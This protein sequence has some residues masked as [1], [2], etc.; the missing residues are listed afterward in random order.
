M[1]CEH[2]PLTGLFLTGGPFDFL[3]FTKGKSAEAV[4]ELKLKE[5]KNARLAMVAFLGINMQAISTGSDSPI[6]NLIAQCVWDAFCL[7]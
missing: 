6:D 4:N 5:I 1:C 3:G 2:P 7:L